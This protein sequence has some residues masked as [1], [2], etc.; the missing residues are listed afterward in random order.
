MNIT[1]DV[2]PLNLKRLAQAT[3]IQATKEAKKGNAEAIFWL[4]C[5]GDLFFEAAE[6]SKDSVMR[7]I[8]DLILPRKRTPP[9]PR[10]RVV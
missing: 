2:T 3:I 10:L 5:A 9:A 4:A 8:E 6:L 7:L 1:N